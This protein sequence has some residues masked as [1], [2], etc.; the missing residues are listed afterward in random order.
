MLKQIPPS[1]PFEKG[2]MG[3]FRLIAI[4]LLIISLHSCGGG[5][6][7]SN[8]QSSCTE[9]CGVVKLI[10]TG[11]KSFNPNI[12]HGR[13]V[14]YRVIVTGDGIDPPII[15]EF[16]GSATEGV[17]DGIPTG[18]NRQIVVEAVNAN[19]VVI[20]QGDRP[21]VTVE[22]GKTADVEVKLE[23]V[24]IFTNLADKSI[25]ENT[26]L[27]FQIFSDPTNPVVVED[28]TNDAT[29]MLADVSTMATEI[30]LDTS[31]GLGKMAPPIQSAGEHTYSVR[32]VLTGRLSAVTVKLLDGRKRKGAPFVAAGNSQSTAKRRLTC[33]TH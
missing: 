27:I 22:G 6:T 12:D 9:P 31:T 15:A 26:R 2:G 20:R 25:I 8:I 14:S 24:P 1:P 33:G 10:V 4:L 23:S 13:I 17:I 11:S 28:I 21:D 18:S 29:A 3:G 16:D 32:N 30:N 19:G 5:N 7:S